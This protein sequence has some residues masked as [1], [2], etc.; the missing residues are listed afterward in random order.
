[1]DKATA[2][3]LTAGIALMVTAVIIAPGATLGAFLD[4][5]SAAVVLGGA[6]AATSIAFP[7]GT[8]LQFPRVARKLL[9]PGQRDLAPVISQL[10]EFA[11]IARRDGILA[12]ESRSEDIEDPFLRL[13]VQMAV[14]GTETEVLEKVLRSEIDS[15]AR[16]HKTGKA[17]FDALGRYAPAFGMVGTLIGLIIML[18]NMDDPEAIGPGM[19]VALITT[20]YG[21]VVANLFCL[22]CADKL[23]FYS[24]RELEIREVIIQGIMAIQEGDNPRVLQQRLS[25]VLPL[26]QRASLTRAA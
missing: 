1:M 25:T 7:V 4:L 12:L 16:R 6:L 10:V 15:V 24:K 14:D 19:A 11:E 22:P 3:G 13:G 23:A 9:F 17:M 20:L 8:L 18:G 26:S 2:A 21:A 5:P